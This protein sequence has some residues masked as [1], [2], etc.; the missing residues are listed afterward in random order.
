MKWKNVSEDDTVHEGDD[1]PEI[2][3]QLQRRGG[4]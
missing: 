2:R 3:L 1:R 4:T